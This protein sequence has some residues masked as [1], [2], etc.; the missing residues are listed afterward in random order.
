MTSKKQDDV[1]M[2]QKKK[3]EKQKETALQ[4]IGRL[5]KELKKSKRRVRFED[6][7]FIS[8]ILNSTLIL[9]FFIFIFSNN[10]QKKKRKTKQN[11]NF[12]K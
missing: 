1:I 4:E 8:N 12:Q 6:G 7:I 2:D 10:K 3:L 5:T 11:A 9:L